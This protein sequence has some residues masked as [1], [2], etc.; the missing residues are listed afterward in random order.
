MHDREQHAA[1]ARAVLERAGLP[2]VALGISSMVL[3]AIAACLFLLPVISIPLSAS[4]AVLG[5]AGIV[6]ALFG[7]T[8]GLRLG[9]AGLA[10][11][12]TALVLVA[13]IA[14]APAGYF[15]PKTI[16]PSMSPAAER[17]YVPPPASL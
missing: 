16:F 13:A 10:I 11:S 3:G 12:M 2:P 17:P 5:L 7:R 14:H 9:V 8:A 4:A 6:A 15:G 1:T